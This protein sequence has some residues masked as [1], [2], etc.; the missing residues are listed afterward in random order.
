MQ[1]YKNYFELETPSYGGLNTAVQFSLIPKEQSPRIE[2]GY[3]DQV[4]DVSKRPGSVPVI[5]TAL[6]SP[7]KHLTMYPFG[8]PHLLASSGTSLYKY[9]ASA[10][11][12]VTMTN[13]LA[14]SNIFDADFTGLHGGNLVNIKLIADGG[15][16]KSYNGTEVKLVAPAADDASPQP[17]NVLANVNSLGIKY[18]WGHSQYIFV[19]PG[20][21]QIWYT[22]RAAQGGT[23]NQY[24][25]IPQIHYL[26][27]VKQGDY[28]N[29]NGIPF[30]SVCF[31]P[32][33]N[34]WCV[35]SGTNFETFDS[36]EFLNTING[37]IAPRSA[38]IITYGNGTQTIAYLSDDGIHEIYTSTLDT[39]GRQYATR[40]LMKETIDFAAMGFTE[41]EKTAAIS[42][43]I[44][45][46]NMYLLEITRDTTNYVYGFDT[47]NAQWYLWKNLQ[48]NSFI[49]DEGIC[50]FAGDDG[51]LRVFDKDLYS[52]WDNIAKTTG[53]PVHFIRYSPAISA[54]FSGYP[55]MWDSY[56]VESQ[57]WL[58]SATLDINFIF[59]NNTDEMI[60]VIKN[61]VFVEGVSQWGFAKYANLNYTDLLNEPNEIMFDYSRLS[62][63]V[64]VLWE[65]DRDEPVKIFKDKWKGRTSQR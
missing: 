33:R 51:L 2:N 45:S 31:V 46:L 59:A 9:A 26:I 61:E 13:A 37:L 6:P 55:S 20:D 7:I 1:N 28:I 25:Y 54:E 52:D 34:N 36:G 63:Y 32:M 50:Y 40:G 22:K 48:I 29:G 57:Q 16:L 53:D 14:T 21:N 56:L 17:P 8:T 24:D 60:K 11:T 38:Q 49:E 12:P 10:L 44:V 41:E 42:K 4:G 18:I 27:A 23:D 65:N 58:V 19:S 35:I 64:Q 15:S 30:D 47:R 62:K 5:S 3:M 39:Q 43:Y